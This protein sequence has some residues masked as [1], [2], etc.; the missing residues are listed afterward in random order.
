MPAL[1]RGTVVLLTHNHRA[2]LLQTLRGL[3]HIANR[4]PIIVVDNGS[5]DGTCKAVRD[6]FPDIFLIRSR[7]NIGAAAR[8]IAVAYV[9]TPYVAFCDDDTQWTHGSLQRAVQVLDEHPKVGVVSGRVLMG[10]SDRIDPAC[11]HMTRRGEPSEGMPGPRLFDF[12]AGA[13]VVR[14]R[15]FYEAGG[16]WPPLSFGGEEAL[17]TLDLAQRGWTVTYIDDVVARRFPRYTGSAPQRGQQLL[18]NAIWVAWMRLPVQQAWKETKTLLR[19]AANDRQLPLVLLDTTSGMLRA[20][21]ARRVVT[22]SVA[23]MHARYFDHAPGLVQK[24]PSM[25]GRWG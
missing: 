1:Q 14:T 21:K 15:A 10:E 22:P 7:R 9:H 16:Y 20:L 25:H 4:W 3:G 2:Q 5:T 11:V 6:E 17:L 12:I 23:A 24:V 13:C 8:N 18:R 19:I